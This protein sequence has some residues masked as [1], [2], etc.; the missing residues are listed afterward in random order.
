M[1]LKE[2][3]L[4][5]MLEAQLGIIKTKQKVDVVNYNAKQKVFPNG[6]NKEWGTNTKE[7]FYILIIII[8]F[9]LTGLFWKPLFWSALGLY[10]AY[11]VSK[12]RKIDVE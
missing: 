11:N 1:K 6:K 5:K 3:L 8:C 4:Q 12:Y 9:A 7:H 10:V 2:K